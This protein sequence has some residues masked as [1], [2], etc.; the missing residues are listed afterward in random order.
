[1]RISENRAVLDPLRHLE[2]FPLEARLYPLGYPLEI[3]TNDP[4]VVEGARE[5]WGLFPPEFDVRPLRMHVA[6]APR[7]GAASLRPPVFRAQRHLLSIVASAENFAVCDL[8]A[9]FSYCWLAEEAASG[10]AW[11]RYHFLEA[12]VYVSLT[13]AYFT[14]IHAACLAR[15]GKGVLLCAPSGT[16]KTVLS[17][18]CARAGWTFISDDVSFLVRGSERRMVLGR[19]Y[20]F[21]FK[22]SAAELFPEFKDKP[23]IAD[24][25]GQKLVEVGSE[26][27]A[28]VH[29]ATCCRVDHLVFLERGE[30]ARSEL[31]PMTS[32]GALE[33]MLAEIPHYQDHVREEQRAS[34]ERLVSAPVHRLIYRSLQ[35]GLDL[36]N[37]LTE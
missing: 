21:R 19:P 8:D 26:A 1:M 32:R 17:Y 13:H 27:S 11:M 16:G 14:P 4:R 34:L 20:S 18:T 23:V 25:N 6:V 9:G 15:N 22:A 28:G 10:M 3:A 35:E 37:T 5:S 2:P 29:T 30:N 33:R 24:A 31:R 7:A 36:L 12:I